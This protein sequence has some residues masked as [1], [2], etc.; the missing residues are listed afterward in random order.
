MEYSLFAFGY[1]FGS[2][3]AGYIISKTLFKKDPR[4]YYS[5]N[6]GATNVA[7]ILGLK[8]G[9]IVFILD[10]LKSYLPLMFVFYIYNGDFFTLAKPSITHKVLTQKI[11]LYLTI[12]GCG[13]VFGHLNPYMLEFKGGKGVATFFGTITG[14]NSVL[15][16]IGAFLWIFFFLIFNISAI[17]SLISI[18]FI[19]I[20]IFFKF[21]WVNGMPI[22]A[23]IILVITSC[24][25]FLKHIEN[26][27]RL[28]QKKEYKF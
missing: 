14:L 23:K 7:R 5:G 13:A 26:I 6:I 12:T 21:F 19:T 25:I 9:I 4:E 24:A 18:F 15:A 17:S 28:I 20:A 22:K 11:F 16:A 27:T 3:P 10:F 1:F 8:I 2:I